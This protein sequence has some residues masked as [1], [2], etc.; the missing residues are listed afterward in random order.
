M[1]LATVRGE[2]VSS[3]KPPHFT[4]ETVEK[5]LLVLADRIKTVKRDAKA[6]SQVGKAVAFGD[7]L[8]GR[9]RV[10][11][12]DVGIELLPRKPQTD[13]PNS[14]TQKSDF[15]RKLRGSSVVSLYPY[16][17]WMGSRTHRRLM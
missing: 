14:A 13:D 16:E 15:L 12:A 5:T 10:Q 17:A 9:S 4:P 2:T 3:S 7:F 8:S 6:P 11:A 1:A